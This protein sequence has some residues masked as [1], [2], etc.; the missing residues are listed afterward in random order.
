[1]KIAGIRP[2][3]TQQAQNQIDH[4]ATY[5]L[6]VR[7]ENDGSVKDGSRNLYRKDPNIRGIRKELIKFADNPKARNKLP[8]KRRPAVTVASIRTI[9]RQALKKSRA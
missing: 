8:T 3:D 4:L 9:K 1:M 5:H 6:I 7:E 2:Q